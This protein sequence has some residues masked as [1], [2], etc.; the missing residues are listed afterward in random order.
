VRPLGRRLSEQGTNG[1]VARTIALVGALHPG[2]AQLALGLEE[3]PEVERI[4]GLQPA[5]A[6]LL[7]PKFEHV[8]AEPGDQRF[9]AAL[10]QADVV[11]LFPVLEASDRNGRAA[12][13]RLA[14]VVRRSL[15]AASRAST[16]VFWSSGIV[17]GAHPDNPVPLDEDATPRP[18]FDFPPARAL[19]EAERMV[20]DTS[21]GTGQANRVVLRGAA[22]WSPTWGSFLSRMLVGPA[23]VGVRGYDPPVQSLDPDDA[24]RAL[25][26]GAGGRLPGGV[27]NVAPDDWIPAA[28]VAR[29]T[30][31]RRVEVP[32]GAAFAVGERLAPLGVA[33]GGPGQLHYHMHP[34]VLSNR[35]LREAGWAPSWSTAEAL[36]AAGHA[37]PAGVRVGRVQ[38][39]RND[40]IRGAAAAVA[41]VAAL[42]ALARRRG[43]RA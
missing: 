11:V 9:D 3:E 12:R 6:P 18:N 15:D 5:P 38:V 2:A 20:L 24:V 40:V 27:Y 39:R 25:V 19:A 1:L 33:V 14:A 42:A 7:G 36:T 26:M 31:K 17:Y 8:A 28:Q 37:V 34:W 10:A 43:G 4:L 35:R 29:L 13:E 23:I 41:F 16:V 30:G 22:I 32:E 21:I